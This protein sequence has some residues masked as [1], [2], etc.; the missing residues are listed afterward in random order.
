M[1]TLIVEDEFAS[2]MVLSRILSSYG[3][4]DIATDGDEAV[5]AFR[6]ALDDMSPYSLICMDIM[7][8]RKDGRAAVQEIRSI[9][10]KLGMSGSNEV[11]ILMTTALDDPKNIVG[12]YKD[13]ATAYLAKPITKEKVIEEVRKLG[14]I[15]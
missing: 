11:K 1:R 3:E 9:E 12:S 10:Q 13:G 15:E 6:I 4:C 7:M 2:R 5:Q 8:P 14:L